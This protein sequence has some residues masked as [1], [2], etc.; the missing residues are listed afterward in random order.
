MGGYCCGFGH[1]VLSR[2]I[3][4]ELQ[5]TIEHLIAEDGITVFFTGGMGDFDSLF[6][7]TVCSYKS[8]H[9]DVK[10]ILVKP[11]FS[12]EININKGYYESFY[13]SVIIPDDIA[14]CHYKSAITKRNR[15]HC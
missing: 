1:R 2:D 3:K 10:L 9:K 6:A 8:N 7:S 5:T 13:D 4:N 12:N 14:G 11:Y 15:L